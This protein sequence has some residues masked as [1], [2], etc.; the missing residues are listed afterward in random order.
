VVEEADTAEAAKAEVDLAEAEKA[1]ADLEGKQKVEADPVEVEKEERDAQ[2]LIPAPVLVKKL[3][4]T[5][6]SRLIGNSSVSIVQRQ[7]TLT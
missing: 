6:P 3:S 5:N 2:G 1:E 4:V 7:T